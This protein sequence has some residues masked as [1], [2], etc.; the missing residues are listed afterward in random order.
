MLCRRVDTVRTKTCSIVDVVDVV[1]HMT[2]HVP[3]RTFYTKIRLSTSTAPPAPAPAPLPPC[4]YPLA[5]ECR[6]NI[7]RALILYNA[8]VAAAAAAGANQNPV[9]IVGQQQLAFWVHSP[10]ARAVLALMG[11]DVEFVRGSITPIQVGSHRPSY[12][13][14]ILIQSR[15]RALENPCS[16]CRS[17][18]PGLRPFPSC[19]RVQGHFGG[20]CANC[21]WRDHAARCSVRDEG[22]DAPEDEPLSLAGPGDPDAGG[23]G[24]A[25]APLLIEDEEPGATA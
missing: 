24:S 19:R 22:D 14:A 9:L 3:T 12:I 4:E 8:A 15:G 20:A 5:C 17:A 21:K 13:N 25:A 18:R 1:D 6:T 23:D 2:A 10:Q 7:G 16:A 11:R